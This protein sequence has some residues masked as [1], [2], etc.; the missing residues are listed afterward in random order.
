MDNFTHTLAA[1]LV[2]EA[3]IAFVPASMP[4]VSARSRRILLIASAITNNLPDADFIY[5][6]ITP[7]K[8]GYLLHH[9]GHTH[10]LPFALLLGLSCFW[11]CRWWLERKPPAS[12]DS[13][14]ALERRLLLGL[15]V[16]GP[17]LH[18]GL[19]ATNN[20]GVHPFWPVYSGWFHGDGVFVVEPW[21]WVVTLPAL[22]ASARTVIGRG[23]LIVTLIAAVGICW[24]YPRLP[25]PIAV[26]LTVV[27]LT[28]GLGAF[29]LTPT[30]RLRGALVAWLIVTGVF[31]AGSRL[32]RSTLRAAL[33]VEP[34]AG[35]RSALD[36]VITPLV[37]N[38]FCYAA[39]GVEVSDSSYRLSVARVSP[40][41]WFFDARHCPSDREGTTARLGS[42]GLP[43]A[44][45]AWYGRWE[46]SLEGLRKLS[47]RCDAAAFLRFART[48]YWTERPSG[49]YVIGDLRYDNSPE[50]DFAEMELDPVEMRC[51]PN[52]P[53]WTP[54][55]QDLLERAAGR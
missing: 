50:L 24:A 32:A 27:A 48:P 29:Q 1:L 55:R 49:G 3:A 26:A 5:A 53:G 35:S 41:P 44:R 19:D 38:P 25:A 7:G 45:V 33:A 40:F 54:P 9:R 16:L 51:P 20:Y 36:V 28:A 4:S 39:I 2:A 6:G 8:L 10:T 43:S 47:E 12:A 15:C 46:G 34:G 17:F 42:A 37:G 22:T 23:V 52:V 31:F 14:R 30:Q 21:L 11:L 13:S 18:I